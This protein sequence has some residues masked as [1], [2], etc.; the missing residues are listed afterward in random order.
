MSYEVKNKQLLEWVKE[1]SALCEPAD[2]HW[3]D[4]SQKEYDRLCAR[5]AYQEHVVGC[6]IS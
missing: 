4:G 2:I 6:P 5:P 1:V 3:C